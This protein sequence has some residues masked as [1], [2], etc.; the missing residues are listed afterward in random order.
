MPFNFAAESFHTEKLLADFLRQKYTFIEKNGHFAFLSPL[1]GL[2]ATYAVY[3]RLVGTLVGDFLLV[4]IELF[5]ARSKGWCATSVFA[6]TRL[7]CPKISGRR[8]HP[9]PTICALLDRPMNA[10]QHCRWKFSRKETL[11]QTFVEIS[12][13]LEEK[14]PI[15]VSEPPLRA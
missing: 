3:L 2:R 13:R 12:T 4:I 6:A 11:Q 9:P 7:V 8:G 15:C 10:L 14:W 5:F 1:W